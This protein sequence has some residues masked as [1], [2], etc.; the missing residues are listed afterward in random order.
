MDY[1]RPKSKMIDVRQGDCMK[2][3]CPQCNKQWKKVIVK[4]LGDTIE[5]LQPDCNCQAT[6]DKLRKESGLECCTTQIGAVPC[7]DAEDAGVK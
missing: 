5:N 7:D 1:E 3:K 6:A 4:F 2:W